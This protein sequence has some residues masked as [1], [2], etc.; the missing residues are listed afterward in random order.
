MNAAK[1]VSGLI[2]LKRLAKTE[3]E[4]ARVD[5]AEIETAKAS[6]SAAM[7]ALVRDCAE[8]DQSAKTDPAFLSANI[9]FREGVVLRREALRKAGFA[10]EKAEAE[11]RDRLDQAV[12][13]Y[14][15]LEILIAVDAEKAGK[16]A[17]KQEIAGADDWAARAASKSN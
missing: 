17:K 5:L 8:A 15:K 16:A 12:Q 14:K 11:I 10:L 3:I 7:E 2:K 4:H 13:E 9:Q 6:N 1:F